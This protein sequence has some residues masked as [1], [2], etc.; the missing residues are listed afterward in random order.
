MD[1]F[2]AVVTLALEPLTFSFSL[3]RSALAS[4]LGGGDSFFVGFAFSLAFTTSVVIVVVFV[5]VVIVAVDVVVA[6]AEGVS[7][8]VPAGVRCVATVLPPDGAVEHQQRH[9]THPG[10]GIAYVHVPIQ[11]K[12]S[13]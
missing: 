1:C 4:P 2:A 9:H 5:V 11:N 10:V 13:E 6:V 3:T 7:S 12:Q 8:V